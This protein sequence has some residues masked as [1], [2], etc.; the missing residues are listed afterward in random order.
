M[1]KLWHLSSCITPCRAQFYR[2]APDTSCPGWHTQITTIDSAAMQ[3]STSSGDTKLI[4]V[5]AALALIGA[6]TFA[7]F[8]V[9]RVPH[10]E[11]EA[12]Y[13]F[14]AKTLARGSLYAPVQTFPSTAFIP[15]VLTINGH[16]IG[17][18]PIGW[19]MLLAIG[20]VFGAGW[21]VNPILGALTVAVVYQIGRDLFDRQIGV[22]AALFLLT[23]PFFLISSSNFMSHATAGL[24]T[25]LLIYAFL[26]VERADRAAWWAVV[27]GI[28]VGMLVLTRPLTAIAVMSPFSVVLLVRLIRRPLLIGEILTLYWPTLLSAALVALIQPLYLSLVTGSMTTNLYT[29][30][31][32]Y[33][34][35]GFGVGYGPMP[36]GHSLHQ[37]SIH[38]RADVAYWA[39]ILFGLRYTSWLL[40]L[41]GLWIGTRDLP[42]GQRFWPWLMASI[43]GALVLVYLAYWV[44]AAAYGPRYYY[45]AAPALAVLAAVGLR[46]VARW[47]TRGADHPHLLYGLLAALMAINLGLYM[48]E[49]IGRQFQ[50]YGITRAPL[51]QALELSRGKRVL[52]LVRG[53]HW[54]DYAA[55]FAVNSPWYD[56]SLV[57]LHDVNL[58]VSDA[59]IDLYP[60][61]EVWFYSE[62]MFSREPQP[63]LQESP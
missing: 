17:K 12:A 33:D 51:D 16:R 6:A 63:Y 4:A 34:R 57:V 36:E 29:L 40:P 35:I 54:I 28:C 26:R 11:D 9:E 50:L 49:Q 30:I 31:W 48:P 7:W 8:V 27:M 58:A 14:Q 62:D 32:P 52:V 56:G 15:F 47:I 10:L 23:S 18:Y 45:E 20:E 21:L 42:K 22:I 1:V 13:L 19:P 46:G 59:V 24:W 3:R 25:I 5:L 2:I 37:A 44:G 41:F 55:L 53:E 61:R 38:M 60:G 39:S 43:F